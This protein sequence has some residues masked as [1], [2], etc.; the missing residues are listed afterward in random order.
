M[1]FGQFDPGQVAFGG[2]GSKPYVNSGQGGGMP[3]PP[4]QAPPWQNNSRQAQ[5]PPMPAPPRQQSPFGNNQSSPQGGVLGA[6]P[7]RATGQGPFDPTYRQNL[8][9]YAMGQFAPP[10]QGWQIN[11]TNPGNVGQPT[12]GGNAPVFGQPNT[13]LGNALG[14]QNF[15]WAPPQAAAQQ[16]SSPYQNLPYGP[17]SWLDYFMGQ[18]G[19]QRQMQA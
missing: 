13:L 16:P 15:S 1:V 6:S 9:T 11:P 19:N 18:G 5:A 12:G 14:G 7:V 8:S 4:A 3:Q 10:Q 2:G 17:P